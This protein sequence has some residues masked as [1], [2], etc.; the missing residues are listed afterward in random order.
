MMKLY[1][2]PRSPFVRKAMV[3]AHELGLANQIE[4][5]RRV[6]A[7]RVPNPAI[8]DHNPLSKI[9]TLVRADG[10]A[11]FDS[12]VIC[13]YLNELAGGDLFP[14]SGDAKWQV[15]RW[16][17]LANGLLDLLV[18][19][20]NERDYE[21]LRTELLQAFATKTRACVARFEGD[22]ELFGKVPPSI[23]SL[24]IGCAL[25]YLDYRF[26]ELE[27]RTQAP[28]L[29]TW[30]GPVNARDSFRLTEPAD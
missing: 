15:L 9:P 14:A 16:H 28:R 26:P 27:W 3:C 12:L 29:A 10:T 11:L 5:V 1:W 30:F 4:L 23:G 2:S 7:M 25:G 18:L 6:A 17:A 8:M 13:Q 20:R 22:V 21:P 19:W 24:T